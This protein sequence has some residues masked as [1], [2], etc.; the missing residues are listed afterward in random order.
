MAK[1]TVDAKVTKA[2]KDEAP[3]KPAGV[4][5]VDL[6]EKHGLNP[7]VVRSRFRRLYRNPET[8]KDLP[9]PLVAGSWTFAERDRAEVE[10]LVT[11][12]QDE[13]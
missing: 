10:A 6:C 12:E 4:R 3:A 11:N 7:K 2:T 1:K 5:V 13:S 8:A 9:K